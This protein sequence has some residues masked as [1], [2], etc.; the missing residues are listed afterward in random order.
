MRAVFPVLAVLAG[1]AMAMPSTLAAASDQARR[2]PAT[3]AAAAKSGDAAAQQ[4]YL[5]FRP[6]PN[7]GR[8][9]TAPSSVDVD[10]L[11]SFTPP[12]LDAR[13]SARSTDA[14]TQTR[15]LT[16]RA[17]ARQAGFQF[18]PSGRAND[19]RVL[20]ISVQ[21][22][23]IADQPYTLRAGERLAAQQP[24][25]GA[26]VALAVGYRGFSVEAGYIQ[27]SEASK[28]LARG[29]DVGVSY[30]GSDWKT[31]LHVTGQ[32]FADDPARQLTPFAADRSYAVELGAAY[33][34]S[35]SVAL[36]GG[37]RYAITTQKP[38][39]GFTVNERNEQRSGSVF[40]GTAVNF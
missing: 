40:L 37:M 16:T 5:Y 36:T 25:T 32:E 24:A 15:R 3:Q 28:A 23:T 11:G 7:A 33:Q 30:R 4:Q 35:S 27:L 20:T 34:I 21:G 13:Q 26:N 18:T 19:P 31:S 17:Q 8:Q 6:L 14:P 38:S 2:A 10:A 1:V 29:V 22:E 9:R 12:I 39:Y